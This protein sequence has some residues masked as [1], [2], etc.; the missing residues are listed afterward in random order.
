MP[1]LRSVVLDALHRAGAVVWLLPLAEGATERTAVESRETWDNVNPAT[2]TET[3]A[4][5][6][7]GWTR[8]TP[9]PS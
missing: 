3:P 7:P 2:L 9:A 6:P 5:I 8:L 1:A 4:P